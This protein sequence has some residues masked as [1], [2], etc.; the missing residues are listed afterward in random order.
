MREKNFCTAL[1]EIRQTKEPII[2]IFT[3]LS[4]SENKGGKREV[5]KDVLPGPLRKN[6][7]DEFMI[8]FVSSENKDEVKHIYI[9]TILE[10]VNSK[11][12]H[13]KL[14]LN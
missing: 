3:K 13:F 11:G 10:Y 5:L 1:K 12:E 9:H 14:K 2:I 4:L 7:Q 6:I 8:G